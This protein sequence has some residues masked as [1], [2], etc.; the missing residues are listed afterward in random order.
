MTSNLN[1]TC[2][3]HEM[4]NRVFNT[5]LVNVHQSILAIDLPR[6]TVRAKSCGWSAASVTDRIIDHTAQPARLR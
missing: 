6:L 2:Y 4:A 1:E 3:M 5:M